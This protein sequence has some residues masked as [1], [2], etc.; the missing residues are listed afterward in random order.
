MRKTRIGLG[1][2]SA[3]VGALTVSMFAA[4]PAA[5]GPGWDRAGKSDMVKNKTGDPYRSAKP[6]LSAGG[7]FMVC[8][9]GSVG[10]SSFKLYE[11]DTGNA[12]D[13]VG[14][15][16]ANAKGCI[17]ANKIG[18]YVDGSNNRAEFYVTTK[19][20]GSSYAEYWD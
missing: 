6:G 7:N 3:A 15:Y 9:G 4:G 16:G 17:V 14:T 1:I 10:K 2:A 11:A 18:K 12:D 19:Y 20:S 8:F 5:A 13:Y